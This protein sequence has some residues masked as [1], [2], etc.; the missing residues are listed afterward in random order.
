MSRK[1]S[2][3]EIVLTVKADE[4]H[5]A[6]AITPVSS[7]KVTEAIF[8]V[9]GASKGSPDLKDSLTQ[10]DRDINNSVKQLINSH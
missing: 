7:S 4:S 9:I 2:T 1:N 6:V 3:A 5:E 10:K 8:S